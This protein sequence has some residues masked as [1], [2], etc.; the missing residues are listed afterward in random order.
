VVDIVG[1][2]K[3]NFYYYQSVWKKEPMVHILPHWNWDDPSRCLGGA[4]H[5]RLRTSLLGGGP[6]VLVWAYSNG[7][8]VEL[9]VNGKSQG[10]KPTPVEGVSGLRCRHVEWRVAY[11]AGALEAVAYKG[12]RE[13]A[14]R[15]VETT[16]PPKALVLAVEWPEKGAAL[17][18]TGRDVALVSVSVVDDKGRVVPTATGANVTF[19]LE[20]PGRIVGLGNGDPNSH[21]SDKPESGTRGARTVFNGR[22]AVLL[23]VRD[24][25]LSG[26]KWS[27]YFASLTRR[28]FQFTTKGVGQLTLK[29]S[30]TG[31]SPARLILEA[32]LPTRD[33]L[34]EMRRRVWIAP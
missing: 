5:P 26:W 14:R 1:F 10:R 2:P 13:W 24:V 19:A 21:E 18:A 23:Q 25:G 6:E 31:L 3:D 15:R 30:S 7:E 20:G 28:F 9:L 33:E 29:A 22:A 16:G 27:L 11:E 32:E 17:A 8:E 12:G 34:T 4:C